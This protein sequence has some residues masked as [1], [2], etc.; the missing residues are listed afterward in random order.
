MDNQVLVAYAT[1]Y[2]ATEEIAE[3][4]G[5]ILRRV[6]LRANLRVDV[7]AANRVSDLSP[8]GAVVL[9]SAVY[10]GRW[11]KEA[12]NF[13]EANEAALAELPVWLFSSGPTGDGDPLE[14]T[15][16]WQF[17][18]G[19]QEVASRIRPRD[20]A[21][22][23]GEV[24]VMRLNFFEKWVL[25]NVKSSVGDYRDWDAITSWAT[26]IAAA[27]QEGDTASGPE[28]QPPSAD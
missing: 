20:I 14:L 15:D 26:E 17:P 8:Y 22:F 12:A 25:K 6:G 11:R 10:M 1:K 23:H 2:G 3:N 7:L 4:I 13:L 9:G 24:N 18:K 28:S 27:L 19:L 21:V 16:G 5:E